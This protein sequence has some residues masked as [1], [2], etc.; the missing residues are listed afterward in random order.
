MNSNNKLSDMNEDDIWIL[1]KKTKDIKLRD[2]LIEKYAPLV[3]YVAGKVAMGK[4]GNI[5]YDD[6]VG[7]GVFGLMDAIE[8]FDLQKNVKFK[9]YAV[10]RIRGSIYDELRSIDWVPRS[11]RT[12]AKEVEQAIVKIEGT[13]GKLATDQE[14]ADE[15]GLDIREFYSTLTKISS[16]SV[17]S[18]SDPWFTGDDNDKISILDTIESPSKMNPDIT[19]ERDSVKQLIVNAINELPDKE[20]KVL[21]LYYYEDLTL[22]EI[23]EVLAVTE[24]RVSQLHTKA[25]IRLKA[26]LAEIKE[27]IL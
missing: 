24:S 21:V 10:T 5:E 18:L 9:T 12:K 15:L 26:K 4:P 14:I 17:M 13:T 20:K 8:K 6:L 19:V 3:K 22:K 11:V 27:G 23:G 25:I 1:Y 16:T 2:F 7:F